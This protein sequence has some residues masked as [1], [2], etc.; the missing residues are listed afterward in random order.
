MKTALYRHYDVNGDLLYVGI[1]LDA[2]R[3][4]MQHRYK[5]DWYEE[6]CSI[7]LEWHATREHALEAE[8]QAI[9]IEDPLFNVQGSTSRNRG[10]S[11]YGYVVLEEPSGKFDGLYSSH[12]RAQEAVEFWNENRPDYEHRIVFGDEVSNADWSREDLRLQNRHSES[13]RG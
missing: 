7:D 13:V 4:L 12:Y 5:S 6:I 8:R 9:E 11:R 3:R 10:R 1:S 2:M